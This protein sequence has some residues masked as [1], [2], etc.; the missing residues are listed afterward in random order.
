MTLTYFEDSGGSLPFV[1]SKNKNS[2]QSLFSISNKV[3]V[4]DMFLSRKDFDLGLLTILTPK[5]IFD[6]LT[7]HLGSVMFGL[8]VTRIDMLM[9]FLMSTLILSSTKFCPTNGLLLNCVLLLCFC[10]LI[11]MDSPAFIMLCTAHL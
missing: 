4:R 3:I 6:Y 2:E 7:M 11:L 10:V 9:P 1:I 5:F 8:N